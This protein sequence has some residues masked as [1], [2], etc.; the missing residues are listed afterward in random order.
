MK[1]LSVHNAEK[2]A[3]DTLDSLS[4]RFEFGMFSVNGPRDVCAQRKGRWRTS[5]KRF[6]QDILPQPGV[7]LPVKVEYQV[8][9]HVKDDGGDL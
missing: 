6:L 8:P 4:M 5:E 7:D 2:S 1:G 9:R 3:A